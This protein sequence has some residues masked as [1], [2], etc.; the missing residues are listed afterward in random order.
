MVHDGFSEMSID[1]PGNHHK[2]KRTIGSSF[3]KLCSVTKPKRC[4]ACV[5]LGYIPRGRKFRGFEA[6]RSYKL[7]VGYFG[8]V[9]VL[10][11]LLYTIA[12][13]GRKFRGFEAGRSYKTYG[14][15]FLVTVLSGLLYT[16]ALAAYRTHTHVVTATVMID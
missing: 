4:R 14:G 15:I 11:G 3:P 12:R 2:L 6:G 8:T 13:R 10:S 5:R 16:I 1:R 9:T 7:A